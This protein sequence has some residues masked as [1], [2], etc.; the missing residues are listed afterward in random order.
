MSSIKSEDRPAYIVSGDDATVSLALDILMARMVSPGVTISDPETAKK[1]LRLKLGHLEREEF[2][3]L[4]LDSQHRI[5]AFET[6]FV[7]TVDSCSVY[8]REALKSAL[9]HN[10]AGVI[11]AHNHPSGCATP[12]MADISLTAKLVEALRYIDVRVL[13]H[14]VVTASECQSMAALGQL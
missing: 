3:A 6:L 5:I 9:K 4:W 12:S 14:I 2:C 10:A 13:D 11:F 8:P 1:Y 7:G